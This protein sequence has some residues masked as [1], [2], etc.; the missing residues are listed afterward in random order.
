MYTKY[1]KTYDALILKAKLR[2]TPNT[3]TENHHILPKSFGGTDDKSNIVKLT[4]REHYIVHL[5]LYGHYKRYGTE[6]EMSS[7]AYTLLYFLS[8]ST[9][10]RT[11]SRLNITA[12]N[13][14]M[15]EGIKISLSKARKGKPL[16]E[17]IG[18]DGYTKY[19]EAHKRRRKYTDIFKWTNGKDIRECSVYSLADEFSIPVGG[20]IKVA[21]KDSK[22]SKGW[23][24]QGSDTTRRIK[25]HVQYCE[26]MDFKTGVKITGSVEEIA[27]SYSLQIRYL[28]RVLSGTVLTAGPLCLQGNFN[29]LRKEYI[30][31]HIVRHTFQ[32][33]DTKE[34]LVLSAYNMAK[35][36]NDPNIHVILNTKNTNRTVQGWALKE[37]NE[38]SEL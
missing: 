33:K 4:A 34:I 25:K 17:L 12:G 19:L 14:K 37:Y 7:T 15:F 6:K 5:L 27:N 35:F 22:V 21:Y 26:L 32:N 23:Y 36:I 18:V 13:S 1:L 3:Y 38:T 9:E 11:P 10:N 31:N 30:K 20:L 28:T 2:K 24:I 16:T 8:T 29:T